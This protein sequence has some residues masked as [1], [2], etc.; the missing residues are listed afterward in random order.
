MKMKKILFGLL[1]LLIPT[2]LAI[3]FYLVL[4]PVK[5]SASAV[6][7]ACS[8]G[9]TVTCNA[10]SCACVDGRGCTGADANGNVVF[11]GRCR[12]VD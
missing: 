10:Y 11:R 9:S 2:F 12:I 3:T 8:D 1:S 7:A 6:T 5:V 4:N